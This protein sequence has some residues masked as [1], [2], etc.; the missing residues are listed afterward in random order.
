MNR[1]YGVEGRQIWFWTM[2]GEDLEIRVLVTT[3][4]VKKH[5]ADANL[6][7]RFFTRLSS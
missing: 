5:P 3:L 7:L 4:L 2:C 1:K 6:Q